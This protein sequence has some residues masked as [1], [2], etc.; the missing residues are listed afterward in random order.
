MLAFRVLASSVSGLRAVAVLEPVLIFTHYI[1]NLP[2]IC[3]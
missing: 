1:Y 2:Q 3:R